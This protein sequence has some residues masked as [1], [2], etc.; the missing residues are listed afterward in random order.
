VAAERAV[1]DRLLVFVKAPRPGAVK[2]RL[3]QAL[4]DEGAARVYR[5]LAEEE[6]RRTAPRAGEY[7]RTFVFTPN[8]ARAEIGS[9]LPGVALEPQ[10]GADLG[11]R[12]AR[13]FASA[14]AAGARRVAI[15]GSDVPACARE[16]VL[17]AF[18]SLEEHDVVLGPT[19]DGGYYLI[20]LDRPRPALFQSIPW[21]TPSVLPATAERAGVLGLGVRMLDP[22]RDIDTV[23]DLKAEWP[24]LE[25]L[26]AGMGLRTLLSNAL[27][28]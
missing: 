13:A 25:P 15:I 17:E 3:A 20:A 24:R 12:M 28:D 8:D 2:T 22:L 10:Q 18:R 16:H 23:Q 14:F 26:V 7:D 6:I 11:E 19:H 5:A 1:S 4:G 27:R 9:W 21:S